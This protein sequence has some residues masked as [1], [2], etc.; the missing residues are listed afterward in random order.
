MKLY[1]T[2]TRQVD[3][4]TPISHDTVTVYTCGPTVYDFAHIG[5]WFNYIRMDLLIRT[6]KATG[7]TPNWVMN[8][9]DVGHLVSDA[10]DGEDKLEKGAKR[11]GKTAWE[12]ADYYTKDF[13]AGM[14]I[15]NML[16]PNHIV[17]ATDHI[18][19]QINLIKTLETKGFTYTTS[20]GVYYDTSLFEGYASFARLDL[21]EQQASGRISFN[22][23]KRNQSDFAL[24]KLSPEGSSRDM[25]WD[26]P[27]GKGFP[28]W[29]IECSAMSMKYLGESIDIHT[30]GIDHIPVH[31]TNEI[32]Q[33]EAATGKRFANN[34]M[35]SNHVMVD[36]EKISKSIGNG[37]RLQELMEKGITASAI[38]LNV[39][40]SHYRSQSKFSMPNL[41]AAQNR[42]R[43]YRAMA[44]LRFQVMSFKQD[45][46]GMIDL[47]KRVT[48]ALTDDLDT[49]LV[50]QLLS[51]YQ[52]ITADTLV[53]DTNL[54]E[55]EDGLKDLD[56]LLGLELLS[57]LDISTQQK[58]IINERQIARDAND[59]FKSDQLRDELVSQGISLRDTPMGQIWSRI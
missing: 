31:H 47:I 6:L 50:L 24:W 16:T 44:D 56:E 58:A 54:R 39:L 18:D 26:S 5:H 1:N 23:D 14:K 52:N 28:G 21:D 33:S 17:K 49:P 42:L 41:L 32:A 37:I 45:D 10:D 11:E 9:T 46:I 35:H 36:G 4:I 19:E 30:G 2:L 3:E 51:S 43:D 8:I 38:R 48:N 53:S 55:F 29:H 7:L 15:L 59:W 34:W 57:S 12:V 22:P 40:E 27:W 25:E 13:I 20:D